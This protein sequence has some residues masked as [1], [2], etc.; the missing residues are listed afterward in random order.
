[1]NCPICNSH[2]VSVFYKLYDDRYGYPGMFNLLVC[3]SCDHKFIGH[4]FDDSQITDLYTNYYPRKFIKLESYKPH[5]PKKGFKGWLYGTKS[6]AYTYVPENVRV[7]DIGCG[8]CE[9][10]GYHI[11]RG[12]EAYGTEM[13]ENVKQIIEKF[14]FNVKIG[15][16]DP[17]DYEPNFFDYITM[18]QVLE[19][20]P[21]PIEFLRGVYL[22]L[23]VGGVCVISTPNATGWGAKLFG[24]K[25]INWHAPY[26]L[27][28]FSKNSM[29]IAA[30]SAGFSIEK[31]K[32]ITNSEWLYFQWIHLLTY[33]NMGEKSSFW[34]PTYNKLSVYK[35]IFIRL[36]NAL[37]K[38]KINHILTR[39]FDSIGV[40]DN[41][42][43]ILR[44]LKSYTLFYQF[45]IEK[46]LL[47]LLL[48]V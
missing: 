24:R 9:S 10:L 12:C 23:K 26:H 3:H 47:D 45:T 17:N 5:D 7:L 35:R 30:R 14:G 8:F 13:D 11:K 4:R 34:Y 25:W 36:I 41:F 18:D 20:I 31:I 16:F 48:N 32:T 33:P 19:H 38:T 40:G 29:E 28:L 15:A 27:N 2:N 39:F 37:H 1:M 46:K 22:I 44:K 6:S 42:I 43:I 21:N